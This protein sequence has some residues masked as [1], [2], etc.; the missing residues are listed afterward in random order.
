MCPCVNSEQMH[1]I[2]SFLIIVIITHTFLVL[3]GLLGVR[4][5]ESMFLGIDTLSTH[6]GV[7][8]GVQSS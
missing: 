7:T 5:L 3:K 6:S 2:Q 4:H 8:P 1:G